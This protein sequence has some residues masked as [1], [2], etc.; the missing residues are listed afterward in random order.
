MLIAAGIVLGFFW[1]FTAFPLFLSI[2]AKVIPKQK[3]IA[4][5]NTIDFACVIT[6]Y[7]DIDC[8]INLVSSLLKQEYTS[9]HI[10][11]VADSCTLSD[12]ILK[13]ER[14]T[15]FFPPTALNSKVKSIHYGLERLVREHSHFI[16]F[17]PDNL[18]HPQY[19]KEMNALHQ[20]G[21]Q[22]VQGK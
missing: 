16:V 18:A 14:L 11:L 20:Q 6:A 13:H 15:V 7:K 17:D 5:N 2:L 21:F 1:L 12:F 4:R 10:Y 3:R 9:Y 22:I 19:L 8:A